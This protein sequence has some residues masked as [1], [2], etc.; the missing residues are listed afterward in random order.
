MSIDACTFRAFGS[1]TRSLRLRSQTAYSSP[2][3]S[4]RSP[5]GAMAGDTSIVPVIF[6]VVRSTIAMMCPGC[7]LAP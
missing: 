2:F 6:R 4:T 1:M 7:G 5:C 3:S